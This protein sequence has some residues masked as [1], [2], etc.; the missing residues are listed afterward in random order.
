MLY[1][2]NNFLCDFSLICSIAPYYELD[3]AKLGRR[4]F[5]AVYGAHFAKPGACCNVTG[6][7]N[8]SLE[9]GGSTKKYRKVALFVVRT[10]GASTNFGHHREGPTETA[11]PW[12]VALGCFPW[13]VYQASKVTFRN[14]CFAQIAA[15]LVSVSQFQE[16]SWKCC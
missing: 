16:K 9:A 10:D 6:E 2:A 15:N 4:L 1:I 11:Q 5:P 13:L 12:L 14:S 7:E 8:I 3:N